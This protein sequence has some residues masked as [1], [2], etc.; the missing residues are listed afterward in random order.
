[1][2][3]GT[4]KTGFEQHTI[5]L[6]LPLPQHKRTHNIQCK[7]LVTEGNN[8]NTFYKCQS[9]F[10]MEIIKLR[11]EK[12]YRLKCGEVFLE[13][14]NETIQSFLRYVGHNIVMLITFNTQL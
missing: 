14:C 3:V 11:K 5:T 10:K 13:R 1:M 7:A 9:H 2:L 12:I 4:Y 6:K 8:K